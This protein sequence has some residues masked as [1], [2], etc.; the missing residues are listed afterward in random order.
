M[1]TGGTPHIKGKERNSSG[2]KK[3][4]TTQRGGGEPS[5]RKGNVG[6]RSLY[7]LLHQTCFQEREKV[8][9]EGV[10]L[11]SRRKKNRGVKKTPTN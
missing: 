4:S 9:R 8:W 10:T 5:S 2:E 11:V 1:I 6:A 3:D 7:L